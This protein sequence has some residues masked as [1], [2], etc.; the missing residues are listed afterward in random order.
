MGLP[1]CANLVLAGYE[2]TEV[3]RQLVRWYVRRPGA[4]FPAAAS[5]SRPLTALKAGD[6]HIRRPLALLGVTYLII[7]RHPGIDD[8][9]MGELIAGAHEIGL[10]A[11]KADPAFNR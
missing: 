2:V 6:A 4:K 5:L 8:D 3:I 10:T 7:E 9:W 1:M 11:E